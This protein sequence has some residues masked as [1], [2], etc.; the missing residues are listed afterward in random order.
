MTSAAALARYLSRCCHAALVSHPTGWAC[1]ECGTVGCTRTA[2]RLL[3]EQAVAAAATRPVE[4]YAPAKQARGLAA[5]YGYDEESNTNNTQPHPHSTTY[6]RHTDTDKEPDMNINEAFPSRYLS[7]TADIPEDGDLVLTIKEIVSENVGQ[8]AKAE[9]KPVIYFT[10]HKK[11]LIVNKTNAKTISG[12]YGAET[13]GWVGKKLALF[14]TEVDFQGEQKLAI[15]VRLKA[16]KSASTAD[17]LPEVW[18]LNRARTELDKA[19]LSLA[20][21][22]AEQARRGWGDNGSAGYSASRDTEVVKALIANVTA[23]PEPF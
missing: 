16:P 23:A 15:R 4:R 19:G 7:A 21:L 12:L 1:S 22:K 13:D 2:K 14:A 17:T 11:G 8:G 9:D 5:L 3:A 20:D 10:E 18:D 6:I